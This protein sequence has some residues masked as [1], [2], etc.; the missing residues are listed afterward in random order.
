MAAKNVR[1][2]YRIEAG[3]VI[4]GY[5]VGMSLFSAAPAGGCSVGRHRGRV[6]S[7]PGLSRLRRS[8]TAASP[9]S[10]PASRPRR[11]LSKSCAAAASARR[12][13]SRPSPRQGIHPR[14]ERFRHV[15]PP[16][17]GRPDAVPT[18]PNSSRRASSP[19]AARPAS[20]RP[21]GCQCRS[22]PR[23]AARRRPPPCARDCAPTMRPHPRAQSGPSS[24]RWL[25]WSRTGP[26]RSR[27]RR[28]RRLP[29]L[30]Y[31][32][33]V[34]QGGHTAVPLARAMD[35]R[36]YARREMEWKTSGPS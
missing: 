30:A 28:T 8:V 13:P 36:G 32:P 25:R 34:A 33:P 26:P 31:A 12:P 29:G 22:P 16:G 7:Q 17:R 10:R 3:K 5:F 27:P 14:P 19:S 1:Y 15:G 2:F 9:T 24:G 18:T 21:Y 11:R 6:L 20:R 4:V 35:A 23:L